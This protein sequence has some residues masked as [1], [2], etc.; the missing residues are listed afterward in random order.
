VTVALRNIQWE[1]TSVGLS[2]HLRTR[3][4]H[5]NFTSTVLQFNNILLYGTEP[6]IPSTYKYSPIS[7]VLRDCIRGKRNAEVYSQLLTN[8]RS[9][10]GVIYRHGRPAPHSSYC[11]THNN[12]AFVSMASFY[13][14]LLFLFR[15]FLLEVLH[16]KIS[17]E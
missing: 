16:Y 2:L 15:P 11:P 1:Y 17:P 14:P 9:A 3:L 4:F 5:S 13:L 7:K 6:T 10:S 8:H 12:T